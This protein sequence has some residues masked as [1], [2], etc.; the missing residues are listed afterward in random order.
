[1]YRHLE[2]RNSE[3]LT[4]RTVSNILLYCDNIETIL[5]LEGWSKVY[6]SD[7]EVFSLDY[8]WVFHKIHISQE[9]EIHMQDCN[10]NIK[11]RESG[12]DSRWYEYILHFTIIR[13]MIFRYVSL[14]QICQTALKEKFPRVEG[15]EGEQ[16]ESISVDLRKYIW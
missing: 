14:Y 15:W 2:I 6:Q 9:L 1:M 16:W 7:I 3:S 10:G 8:C 12:R 5:D 13:N 11:L 4:M